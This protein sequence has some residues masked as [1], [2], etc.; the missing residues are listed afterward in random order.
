MKKSLGAEVFSYVGVFHASDARLVCFRCFLPAVIHGVSNAA[1]SHGVTE[2][3]S[4]HHL[5]DISDRKTWPNQTV[6]LTA[7]LSNN[8][9]NKSLQ[10]QHKTRLFLKIVFASFEIYTLEC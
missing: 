5:I 2:K 4:S 6:I 8:L 1:L 10:L 7:Q 3:H 9:M